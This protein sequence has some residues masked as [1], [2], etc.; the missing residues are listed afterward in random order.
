MAELLRATGAHVE[1]IAVTSL[2]EKTFYAVISV[3]VDG[4]VDELDARPSD[5]L[6]LTV[7]VGA[8]VFVDDGVPEPCAM[9]A[10]DVHARLDAEAHEAD[11]ELPLGEWRSLSAELIQSLYHWR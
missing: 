9:R 10:A 8:P 3:A 11:H 4:R 6:N 2:R 5:A 1:R 7:R